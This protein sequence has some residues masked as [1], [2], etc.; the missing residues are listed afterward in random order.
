MATGKKRSYPEDRPVRLLTKVVNGDLQAWKKFVRDYCGFLYALAWR[1]ARNDIDQASELVLVALEGLRKPGADGQDFYRLRKYL[2]SLEQYGGRSRFVTWLA[3]VVKN[4]FRDWF[5][6][7]EGR[8]LLPKEI[9]DLSELGRDIYKL[10]FW[11]G[12][13]ESEA[14]ETLRSSKAALSLDEFDKQ[15]A[16]IF[17]RLSEKNMQTIYTDLIRRVPP[18]SVDRR[19]IGGNERTIELADLQPWSRP[20]LALEVAQQQALSKQVGE[21]LVAAV[22]SLPAQTRSILMMYAVQG[23][24]GAE[25]QKVMGFQKRQRVYDELSKAR[26]RIR[27]ILEKAGVGISEASQVVGWLDDFL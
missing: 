15:L 20:D 13:S 23:M 27:V 19:V 6:E 8:R 26:R 25:I 11:D 24:S 14:F 12:L 9:K 21:K 4:L 5:R 2:D 18:L 22:E 10:V 1:Y 17:D 3:L 16:E 7:N